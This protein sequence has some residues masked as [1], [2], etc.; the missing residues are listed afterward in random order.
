MQ[1]EVA[2]YSQLVAHCD[3]AE[4]GG[5]HLKGGSFHKKNSFL[6][7]AHCMQG[8]TSG[9]LFTTCLFRDIDIIKYTVRSFIFNRFS[10]KPLIKDTFFYFCFLSWGCHF[11][12]SS[13]PSKLLAVCKAK[14]VPSLLG[15][16]ESLG[17]GTAW[18]SN[19]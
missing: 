9:G 18:G 17:I 12:W 8:I 11:T 5:V 19:Q 4:S 13:K 10:T 7:R 16:F 1:Q 2:N 6:L 15:Y 14:A 3:W